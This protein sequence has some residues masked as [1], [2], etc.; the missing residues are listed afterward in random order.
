MS[1]ASIKDGLAKIA[2][3][4]AT[5]Q[6]LLQAIEINETN[7]QELQKRIDDINENTRDL[8]QSLQATNLSIEIL[9][10]NIRAILNFKPEILVD[11][12][13]KMVELNPGLQWPTQ[14]DVDQEPEEFSKDQLA[15][16]FRTVVSVQESMSKKL[17]ISLEAW[18]MYHEIYF[19]FQLLTLPAAYGNLSDD[20]RREYEDLLELLERHGLSKCLEYH[21]K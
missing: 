1:I 8:R 17:T 14:L 20:G 15:L 2:A 18:L 11:Y 21:P 7:K 4:K 3:E 13:Q 5:G 6:Y 10:S 9:N 16:L 12:L 19:V